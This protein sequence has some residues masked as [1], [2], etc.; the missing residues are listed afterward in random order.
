MNYS[1]AVMLINTNIRAVKTVYY[2]E[3]DAKGNY[4][5]HV[6]D[7]GRVEVNARVLHKTL[8]KSIG[9]GDYV[10][11]PTKSRHNM[12]VAQVVEVDSEVDFDSDENVEW[13]VSKVDV[14]PSK[15]ILA[16]ES[17]WIETLKLSEKNAKRT[18]IK[19]DML[20]LYKDSG[21]DTLEIAQMTGVPAI[22]HKAS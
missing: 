12:T 1:T 21:I 2:P 18:K 8:D 11:V 19:E 6:N 14:V 4:L 5:T 20:A 7:A 15:K 16:E 22:E 9:V 10:I 3:R 17:K 13:I